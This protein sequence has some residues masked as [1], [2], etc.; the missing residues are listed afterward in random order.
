MKKNLLIVMLA[1]VSPVVFGQLTITPGTQWVISGS[2]YVV[3]ENMDFINNGIMLPGNSVV[4][5]TGNA[6]NSI[7]GS[8]VTEK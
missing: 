4:K 6:N 1:F 5:F 3:M 2:P 8:T 7:G